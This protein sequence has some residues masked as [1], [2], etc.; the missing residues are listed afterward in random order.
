MVGKAGSGMR[1][2]AGM[3]VLAI[4]IVGGLAAQAASITKEYKWE[5]MGRVWTL[6]HAYA[7]EVY[8]KFRTMPRIGNYTDY[9][10]YVRNPDDD[11]A[12]A[13][14]VD[15]MESLC[16]FGGLD[17]W[18]E[19][20]LVISF[21]QSLR[22]VPEEG[23]YPRYPIETLVEGCGD[24][25]DLAILAA[26][27]LE[28]IGFDVVLLAFTTEMHM[29]VGIHVVLPESA[30]CQAYEWNG[31]KYYYVETTGTGWTLGRVP[32]AYRSAPEIIAVSSGF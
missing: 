11:A 18:G 12:L 19:L 9:A 5:S 23:E 22:Y 27:M 25:E 2:L 29:A 26:A 1:K 17:A 16:R 3:T 28:E 13:S 14:L 7:F 10:E 21:V 31:A 30:G 15:E 32:A 8:Q 20:D 4:V 24:C 6:T